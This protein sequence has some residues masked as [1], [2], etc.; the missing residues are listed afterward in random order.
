MQ[1]LETV[2][3]WLP[4]EMEPGMGGS[5]SSSSG[6]DYPSQPPQ[7]GMSPQQ[8]G[9][10]GT[11]VY[12]TAAQIPGKLSVIVDTGAWTN[13]CGEGLA[14]QLATRASQ[15]GKKVY[16]REMARPIT[17]AGVGSGQQKCHWEVVAPVAIP[18]KDGPT[19]E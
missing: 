11:A 4:Q 1:S 13:L 6:N 2:L 3:P 14:K 5:S 19:G 18:H 7:P 12:H 10:P 15:N 16:D 8:P 9:M 17:V